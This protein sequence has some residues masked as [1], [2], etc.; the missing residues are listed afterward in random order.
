MTPLG[1]LGGNGFGGQGGSG[2][3]LTQSNSMR[4]EPIL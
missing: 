3:T 2:F 1:G 4:M